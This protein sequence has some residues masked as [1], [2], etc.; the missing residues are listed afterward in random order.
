MKHRI[1]SHLGSKHKRREERTGKTAR[2]VGG[3]CFW[4]VG[5]LHVL[6]DGKFDVWI[7]KSC[8]YMG[9][10]HRHLAINRCIYRSKIW[11]TDCYAMMLIYV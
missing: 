7:F 8:L 1:I 2:G 9:R 6:G 10:L 3:V 11:M 4:L 5:G